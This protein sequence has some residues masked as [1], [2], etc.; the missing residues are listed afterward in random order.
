VKE[1]AEDFKKAFLKDIPK[2]DIGYAYAALESWLIGNETH[3]LSFYGLLSEESKNSI[4][5]KALH[6]MS[7][8]ELA[9]EAYRNDQMEVCLDRMRE[10]VII[11]PEDEQI[12]HAF[13]KL[14]HLHSAKLAAA[15]Q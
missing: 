1:K 4:S 15:Y 9:A 13:Q 3:T 7:L 14:L 2:K 11:F 8:A 12:L 6:A 5:M 10:I